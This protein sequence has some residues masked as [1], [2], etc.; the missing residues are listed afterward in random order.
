MVATL[1]TIKTPL[2]KLR[3]ARP[4]NIYGEE[5]FLTETSVPVGLAAVRT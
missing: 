5:Y 1:L 2:P 4:R 3:E